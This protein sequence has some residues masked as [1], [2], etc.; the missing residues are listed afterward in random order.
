MLR[1]LGDWKVGEGLDA[2][3][4]RSFA[5]QVVERIRGPFLAQHPPR[6]VLRNLE[7]AFGFALV[8]RDDEIHVEVRE[9][10]QRGVQVLTH[11]ADQPFIVDTTRLFL[12]RVDAEYWGGFNVILRVR[13][14]DQGRLVAVGENEP[15]QESLALMEV[16]EGSLGDLAAAAGRLHDHLALG[17]VA[18]RDFR[19]M[20]RAVERMQ[21]RCDVLAERLPDRAAAWRETSAFLGWLLKENFVFMGMEVNGASY[22]IQ[23]VDS[24]YRCRHDRPWAQP[25]PPGTVFVRKSRSESPIHRAGRIDEVRVIIGEGDTAEELYIRGMFTYRAVTQPRRAIPILRDVLKTE[26][27][28]QEA[29]PA[30]FRYKGIANVFDSLPTEFLFTT[31]G[32]A[33]GEVVELVLDSEQQ[34]EVGVT[35]LTY[36]DSTAFALLSMPKPQYSDELRRDI[37][38]EI[39]RALGPT[40]SDHGLF[41]GRFDTV[42]LHYYLTGLQRHD[43]RTVQQLTERIRTLATPWESRLWQVIA[44]QEGEERADLLV[45]RWGRGF[46]SEWTRRTAPERAALDV[47]LLDVLDDDGI[48]ADV[49]VEGE[50]ARLRV[51]QG[52]DAFL[53]DLLPVLGN[54]GLTVI[55][56]DA[57]I[58]RSPRGV[59]HIDTFDLALDAD[60]RAQLLAAKE[61]LVDALPAVF[62]RR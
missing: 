32:S 55:R 54:F 49:F 61:R 26:L 24:S 62:S 51:Y 23:S 28:R 2:G 47:A 17:R 16:D 18:V 43:D 35:L 39:G 25:H 60:G 13:R 9:G 41:I 46:S 29:V 8:R 42:L 22:G 44:Q 4:F 59:R 56:A 45:D 48:A 33:I 6:Q 1:A 30:S 27:A 12:R 19:A 20:T 37:E 15:L 57:A 14:D 10:A 34:Q 52:R 53:T 31:P 58:V 21:E 38:A 11:M 40:Y 5:Q 36:D 7:T 50:V 3:L